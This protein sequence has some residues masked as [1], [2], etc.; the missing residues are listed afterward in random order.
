MHEVI[1]KEEAQIRNDEDH[2][3]KYRL[4]TLRLQE[5]K[6]NLNKLLHDEEKS[7]Q[8]AKN[9]LETWMNKD[10]SIKERIKE[11]EVAKSEN[12]YKI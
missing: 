10:N 6:E 1:F 7:M 8:E 12:K 4:E 9:E 11:I 5:E 2:T 3:E